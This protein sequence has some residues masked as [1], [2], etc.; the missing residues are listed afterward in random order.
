MIPYSLNISHLQN[1]PQEQF[2]L[3]TLLIFFF[4]SNS[5]SGP[6][7]DITDIIKMIKEIHSNNYTVNPYFVL[8]TPLHILNVSPNANHI[9]PPNHGYGST[10]LLLNRK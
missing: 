5:C 3:L 4:S 7:K 8:K 1:I 6:N 9:A 10:T 2:L